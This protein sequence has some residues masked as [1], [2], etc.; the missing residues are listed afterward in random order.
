MKT[1][2]YE[3]LPKNELGFQEVEAEIEP[4]PMCG[5][6][7][8]DYPTR[9]VYAAAW[10]NGTCYNAKVKCLNCGLEIKRTTE[11]PTG[12]LDESIRRVL[13]AWNRRESEVIHAEA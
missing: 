7:H 9:K 8:V 13:Y 2:E 11:P 6:K 3:L 12:S 1:S 10:E 4:C 5:S